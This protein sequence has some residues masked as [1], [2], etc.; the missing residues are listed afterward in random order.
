MQPVCIASSV[1]HLTALKY[2]HQRFSAQSWHWALH[3]T[4]VLGVIVPYGDLQTRKASKNHLAV[5]LLVF[6]FSFL[7]L[8]AVIKKSIRNYPLRVHFQ[9][10]TTFWHPRPNWAIESQHS[11]FGAG[12]SVLLA[13]GCALKGA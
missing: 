11:G 1:Y 6:G 10:A 12:V 5:T 2:R 3:C 8:F 13:I 9:G 7:H 4:G